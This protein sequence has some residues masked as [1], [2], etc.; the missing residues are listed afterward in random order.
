MYS[1]LK[2]QEEN[3]NKENEEENKENEQENRYK[4]YNEDIIQIHK[5][6]NANIDILNFDKVINEEI[7]YYRYLNSFKNSIIKDSSI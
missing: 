7:S 6:Y 5:D 2:K 1:F 4:K 3:Q